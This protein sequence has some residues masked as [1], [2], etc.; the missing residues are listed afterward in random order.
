VL[1][2]SVFFHKNERLIM[3]KTL[4]IS[5][6]LSITGALRAQ[7]TLRISKEDFIGKVIENNFQGRIADKQAAMAKA[8][9]EQ[10]NSLYLPSVSASY[11]AITTNN[12]L[13]AFGSKLNQ[14]ILTQQDFNPALLND[15]DNVQNYATE[16]TILQ[17]LLNMDGVYGRKAAKIQKEAYEL[18]AERTK[19]YLELEASKL[20]MQLQLAYEATNVLERAKET[21]D[22][23]VKTVSDYFD[24]GMVQ[25]ADVL[26]AQVQASEVENQL[27]YTRSN[28][29]NLSDQLRALMG[30]QNDGSIL[31]P[32]TEAPLN[33]DEGTFESELPSNRRDLLAM[34]KSVEG[35]ESMFKSSKMKFLPRVN[36]FGSFQIYDNDPLGFN[37]NGY[38]IGAK[39]SWNLFNG[40]TDISKKTKAKLQMEKA[41]IEQE[42]YQTQ[43]QVELSKANRMLRDAQNKV[44][45]SQQAFEQ[46]KESN[47]IRKDRYEQ[48][49]EKTVDLL[50]SVT[51]LYKKELEL[52]QAIFEYNFTKEYLH[53]LTRE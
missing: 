10:S 32:E 47:K 23:A 31:K 40:Y 35:Y 36:A 24:Q 44:E 12:P 11:T 45:L 5:L 18:K 30:E 37:A 39:L 6:L 9:F 1:I 7:D 21:A 41:K 46:A 27:T 52:Q 4:L 33:Y 25:K 50:N 16:F 15:P 19:E 26:D 2:R 53:F 43:Q 20:F 49:L 13:M 48:G 22:R 3:R 8:D 34:S 14:E 17:P 42:E 28:V 29:R 51:Q 38:I